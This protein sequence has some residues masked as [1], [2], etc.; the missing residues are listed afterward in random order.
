V[1]HRLHVRLRIADDS[2][3]DDDGL[4]V[5]PF[6]EA[7][8][9][10]LLLNFA[11]T[12]RLAL[13]ARAATGLSIVLG[14]PLAFKGLYNAFK[15]LCQSLSAYLPSRAAT[16][17]AA[18]AAD[19]AHTPVVLFLLGLSTAL[20]LAVTDIAVP[21][22]ISGA[23]LGAAIIYIFPA[24]ID[25]ASRAPRTAHPSSGAG[26]TSRGQGPAALAEGSSRTTR[27]RVWATPLSLLL[28]PLGS[29]LAIVGT[30]VTLR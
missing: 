12:D 18:T 11:P 4:R 16:L 3:R 7:S 6:G 8:A 28:L 26:P 15:G 20:S 22:G 9:S 10:N 23:V 24:L 13:A 2:L 29:L 21:V 27:R 1:G 14:Y 19:S 30:Y 5:L 17:A 25:G